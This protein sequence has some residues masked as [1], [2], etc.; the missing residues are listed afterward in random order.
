MSRASYSWPL[1]AAILIAAACTVERADVRTP[2]GEPPEA[3]TTQVRR[4]LELIAESYRTG[5]LVALDTIYHEGATIYEGGRAERGWLAYRDNRLAVEIEELSE[6]RL[7]F[8]DIEIRLADGTAL[9]TC[10]YTLTARRDGEQVTTHGLG[11]MV[12]RKFAGRWRLVHSHT[13]E[14]AG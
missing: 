12:F 4:L 6:R 7:S 1:V 2:S 3:D 14:G 13:S 11:T 8:G 5:D 10:N 9:V